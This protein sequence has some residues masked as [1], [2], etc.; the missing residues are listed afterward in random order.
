M[1]TSAVRGTLTSRRLIQ[2]DGAEVGRLRLCRWLLL[3]AF[4]HDSAQAHAAPGPRRVDFKEGNNIVFCFFFF[5]NL[6]K[7][8]ISIDAE[9][10][11]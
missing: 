9:A 4:S 10:L 1:S 3:P 8:F 5:K 7:L 6:A 2:L 11:E